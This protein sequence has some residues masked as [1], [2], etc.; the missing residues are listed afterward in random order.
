MGGIFIA[1][2]LA[3]AVW[4]IR[5]GTGEAPNDTAPGEQQEDKIYYTVKTGDTLSEIAERYNVSWQNIKAH[6]PHIINEHLIYP[7]QVIVIPMI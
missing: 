1:V 3:L 2:M 4:R 6:N 7:G 5:Q